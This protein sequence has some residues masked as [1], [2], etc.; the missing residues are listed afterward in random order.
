MEGGPTSLQVAV[1]GSDGLK[2]L[3]PEE[4]AQIS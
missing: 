4:I 2:V 1:L 3:T